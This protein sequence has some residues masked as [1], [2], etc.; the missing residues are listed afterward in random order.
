MYLSFY[1]LVKKP[2][3][4]SPNPEFLWLGEKHREGLATLKYGILQNKGFLMIT[5]DVGTGKTALIRA[6]E[7]EI[8]AKVIV[9]TIPDPSLSLMDFYNV[10]ASELN[11]GRS[12]ENKGGFLI[13]FKRLVLKAASFHQ[14][15][16]MIID[17]SQR[18]TSALLEEIRLLSNIDLGGNV[19]IN[20]F[21]VGQSEFKALL[22]RSENRAVRQRITVSYEL[23]PLT[24]DETR[25]Y[26]EHRL[27][28]AGASR[29]IFTPEA[30]RLIHSYSRG[31]PRLINIIC[32]HALMSGYSRGVD[33]IDEN[34]IKECGSELKVAIGSDPAE[35]KTMPPAKL[36]ENESAA[37]LSP[38][39]A[40]DQ[41]HLRRGVVFF[42][43]FLVLLGLTWYL[44][45][46]RISDEVARWGKAKEPATLQ[47]QKAPAPTDE[48]PDRVPP[49][50]SGGGVKSK[51]QEVPAAKPP[52]EG[53]VEMKKETPGVMSSEVSPPQTAPAAAPS[54]A[55]PVDPSAVI[56]TETVTAVPI[57]PPSSSHPAPGVPLQAE[58]PAPPA[59]VAAKSPS[60]ESVRLKEFVVYFTQNSTEIPIYAKDILAATANLLKTFPDSKV[61]IEGHTDS[62]GDP[63]YNR[64]ISEVRAAS[65][66]NYLIEQGIEV[67]RLT[68][69]GLGPEKP[70]ET[71]STSEGRSKN[72]RVV[73]RIVTGKQG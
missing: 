2:F 22:A 20:T 3:D 17:E 24:A 13:E 23:S 60:T 45:G 10:M 66:K 65:V 72:R 63:A 31:Y 29:P 40:A 39:P 37:R 41:S 54:P 7:N 15:V 16:L 34:I 12:F 62:T 14:R 38:V 53:F 1:N 69:S 33:R 51:S 57:T 11:M 4:I 5:G 70:I 9:V 48:K 73:I 64:F 32:D 25:Q 19:L 52:Q 27:K 50:A 6:I 26:I 67:R 36:Q 42:G 58:E 30:I 55:A 56:R 59:T 61:F 18:L 68:A 8:Q 43:G 28:V 46:D 47:G 44:A 49:L 71:N 21:F 35:E